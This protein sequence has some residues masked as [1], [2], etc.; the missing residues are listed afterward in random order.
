MA[1]LAWLPL[2]GD[3]KNKG[4]NQD[5]DTPSTNYVIWADDG[6]IGNKSLYPTTTTS[7]VLTYSKTLSNSHSYTLCLWAKTTVEA[8]GSRYILWTGSDSG[9]VGFGFRCSNNGNSIQAVVFGVTI[10][11]NTGLNQWHHLAMIVDYE[12]LQFSAYLD[13]VFVQ[14]KNYTINNVSNHGVSIGWLRPSYYPYKGYINDVRIYD[15][16]LSPKEIEEISKGLVLHYKLDGRIENGYGNLVVNGSGEF[17]TT[18]WEH[19]SYI[20]DDVPSGSDALL[21]F[22][23]NNQTIDFIPYSPSV[24]YTFESY[25]KSTSTTGTS[26]PALIPYDIDK[27]RINNPNTR[28]GFNLGTMTTITQTLN[29]GDTKIYVQSLSSWNANSGH[30]YNYAAIFGYRDST[31]YLYPDGVYTR[32]IPSFGNGTDQKINLDKTNNIITLNSPYTGRVVEVGTSVCAAAAGSA[33]YYPFGGI[34][35]SSIQDWTYKST[36]IPINNNFLVAAK[37]LKVFVYGAKQ[38]CIKLT[39]T[40]Y[41]S[42]QVTDSSGYE[43]N[44]TYINLTLYSNSPRYKYSSHF[45]GITSCIPVAYNSLV[46]DNIFTMNLWFKKDALG[47]KNWE[48]L[49]GGPSGFELDTRNNTAQTLSL[50][51]ASTRGTLYS[52]FNFGEWYM[53]TMVRDGTNEIYYV[54]GE[55]SKTIEAKSMPTG[56]YFIGAWKTATSQNLFGEISDFRLYRTPLSASQ[57][58]DLY[59]TSAIIDNTGN[60]SSYQFDESNLGEITKEGI[61][62]FNL[63]EQ[64]LKQAFIYQQINPNLLQGTFNGVPKKTRTASAT[65]FGGTFIP[66]E[67]LEINTNYT[68]SMLIR[69]TAPMNIYTLNTGGNVQFQFVNKDQ[70]DSENYVF[71]SCTFK[72]TGNR[73]INSIY[74]CT[75]YGVTEMGEWFEVLPYSIKLEKGTSATE[76]IPAITDD[77]YNNYKNTLSANQFIEI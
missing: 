76:W 41:Q 43:N 74:I 61:S 64:D 39:D 30:Y 7:G 46:P 50:Y 35:N 28:S 24:I 40:T 70:M 38:T 71:R 32:T 18:N 13:G 9:G 45:N 19:P 23:N 77:M 47:S 44:S 26:Y 66:T 4:L 15:H 73:T 58:K 10:E 60:I 6:K 27:Y 29:P 11:L 25:V 20:S 75:R 16:C 54:N 49:F 14:S 56:S 69:G 63:I 5:Y 1:L 55:H 33:Y 52:K 65:E 51:G 31:G 37:Y 8:S 34:S 42:T 48:T 22:T 17:G 3:L 12:N 53:V 36:T 2:A 59:N 68:I 62:E 57:V 67:Q 21:S 72:V